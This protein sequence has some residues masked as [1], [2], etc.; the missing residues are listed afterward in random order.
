[1]NYLGID[2]SKEKIDCCLFINGISG[3]GKSNIFSN[4]ESGFIKLTDWLSHLNINTND[5]LVTLEATGIY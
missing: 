2:V 4:S 5:L 1:M 3:K